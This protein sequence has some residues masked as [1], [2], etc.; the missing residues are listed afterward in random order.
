M[1]NSPTFPPGWL[2]QEAASA[3]RQML[4]RPYVSQSLRASF[5]NALRILETSERPKRR[6]A[7]RR[8]ATA[9]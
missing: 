9:A 8:H 6:V 2:R 5:R 4:K 3:L 1:R 7:A